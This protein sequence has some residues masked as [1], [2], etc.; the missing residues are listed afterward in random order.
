MDT[1][2]CEFFVNLV[3][4]INLDQFI[5][6]YVVF[7]QVTTGQSVVDAIGQYAV[8]PPETPRVTISS[9]TIVS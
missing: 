4:N 5:Y 8:T 7:G 3:Y 1:A 9:V 6:P 2:T